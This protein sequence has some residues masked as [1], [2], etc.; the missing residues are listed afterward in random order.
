LLLEKQDV[1][2]VLEKRLNEYDDVDRAK[3]N[4]RILKPDQI[5]PREE[6][7]GEIEKAFNSYGAWTSPSHCPGSE[8]QM[9]LWSL[10]LITRLNVQ[11]PSSSLRSS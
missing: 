4:R 9:L 5:K 10:G 11:P 8:G 2:R 7:L 1:L 3:A 6:L